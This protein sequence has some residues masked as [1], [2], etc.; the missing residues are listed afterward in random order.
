[1]LLLLVDRTLRNSALKEEEQ[2]DNDNYAA[3]KL[4][5]VWFLV[6]LSRRLLVG[7][8]LKHCRMGL[9]GLVYYTLSSMNVS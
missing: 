9:R 7:A 5:T 6:P 4:P 1:M 3:R 8:Y 2:N